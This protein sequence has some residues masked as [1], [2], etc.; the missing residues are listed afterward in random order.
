MT[1]WQGLNG[2]AF[3]A[4]SLNLL[5]G[6][7]GWRSARPAWHGCRCLPSVNREFDPRLRGTCGRVR[8]RLP[9][10][11]LRAFLRAFPA[12]ASSANTRTVSD[13]G[14]LLACLAE[15]PGNALPR[16]PCSRLISQLA[17]ETNE[18]ITAAARSSG[19][20]CIGT[21]EDSA[22]EEDK[23]STAEEDKSSTA[24]ED[25]AGSRRRRRRGGRRKD[26]ESTAEEEA[27]LDEIITLY[28]PLLVAAGRR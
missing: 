27:G 11:F 1:A 20:T 5:R 24:E 21:E 15:N 16:R 22:A 10:V 17:E 12:S 23:S 6:R 8:G 25:I 14:H 4:D 13:T 2:L 26:D 7:G 19:N 28:W 9:P 3:T 18:I